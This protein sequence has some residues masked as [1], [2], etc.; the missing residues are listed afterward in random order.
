MTTFKTL[1]SALFTAVLT[2]NMAFADDK[3]ATD[4][5]KELRVLSYNIHIGIGNDEKLDLERTAR[6]IVAQKPDIVA[7]QEIDRNTAR[8]QNVDQPAE[9]ERLTGM[10]AV[11]GKTINLGSGEYGIAILSK[12]P[13][14]EHKITQLPQLG[15]RE[16]RGALEAT[17]TLDDKTTLLFACTHFCHQSE[18][19]R[20]MQAEKINELFAE[21][22]GLVV[23]AGDFNATPNSKTIET[24]KAKWSDATNEQPTFS[25]DNPR[26]KIDYI[27]YRPTQMLRVKETR[28]IEEPVTSD[29]SPVLSVLELVF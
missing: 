20:T 15:N 24:L 10:H 23:I 5:P 12:Y 21:R 19:R 14:K 27:F 7:I 9:L 1:Y 2:C 11:F 28:V 13:I 25:S 3:P 26:S 17:I 8:T 16:D 29:H 6:T 18:E 4:T 22:D